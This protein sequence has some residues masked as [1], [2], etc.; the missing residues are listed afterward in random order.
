MKDLLFYNIAKDKRMANGSIAHKIKRI[1]GKDWKEKNIT[2]HMFRHTFITLMSV[3]GYD[4][5]NLSRYVGHSIK[6]KI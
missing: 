6:E 4:G 1:C 2:P 5:S 3:S